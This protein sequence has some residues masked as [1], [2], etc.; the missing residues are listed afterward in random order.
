M[1]DQKKTKTLVPGGHEFDIDE[2]GHV[3]YYDS[4]GYHAGPFCALCYEGGCMDCRPEILTEK[5]PEK[6]VE[7]LPGLEYD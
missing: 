1:S 3:I 2:N 6:E 5:C 7:T 4:P